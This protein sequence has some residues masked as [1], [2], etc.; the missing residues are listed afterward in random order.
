[1]QGAATTPSQTNN[2]IVMDNLSKLKDS[3]MTM[4]MLKSASSPTYHNGNSNGIN[5]TNNNSNSGMFEMVYVFF[6][7]QLFDVLFKIM[8]A[9]VQKAMKYSEKYFS[10]HALESLVQNAVGSSDEQKKK[11]K[12]ASI[13]IQISISDQ[14]N[15]YGQALLDFITNNNNTNHVSFKK[16]N[17]ILNQKDIIEIE[18][19]YFIL[20]KESI[21]TDDSKV[22][23]EQIIELFSYTKNMQELRT[24][25]NK[26]A[27]DYTIKIKNKLGNK[28]FYFNQHPMN[29]PT[30]IHGVKEFSKLPNNCHFTMK[31]FQTNRKF[32][33]LFG[34]EI[35][36]VKKRV[37][38]FSKNKKWYDKK[39][40]PYTL[41][42]LLSGSPGAGKTSTIKCLANETRRHIIN[43]N[44]NNDISKIQLEN[45][46]FNEMIVVLNVATGINEKYFIPLDQRIYVL[47]DI[48][49]Q[50]DLV[51]N[52]EL[53]FAL[54]KETKEKWC[55]QPADYEPTS[56]KNKNTLQINSESKQ[57]T[58]VGS[59]KIDLAFL[60]NLLDGVLEI[61]GRIVIMTSNFPEHLD[62]ALI[63]PG[64]IDVIANFQ[65]CTRQTIVQMIEFFYDVSLNVWQ[66]NS[67]FEN[68]E[69]F[70]LS[71][72]ELSK[73]MFE[74]INSH[75]HMLAT[76]LRN[77]SK[78]KS[79]IALNDSD[80]PKEDS[81]APKEDSDAPKEDSDAPKEDSEAPK[82]DSEAPKED[83]EAPKEHSEAPKEDSEAPK[84]YSEA[85]KEDSEAP[86]EET[87]HQSN[88][89]LEEGKVY[90]FSFKL[91]SDSDSAYNDD[92]LFHSLIEE[93]F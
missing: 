6:V 60:L 20:L 47:E 37:E 11:E 15:V 46:F 58:T 75:E 41:G 88:K 13:T 29:A 87:K 30:N 1:M 10:S 70:V 83:S 65:K 43:I 67:I 39:G 72:A 74:H 68:V 49:C 21:V 80:A 51:T 12:I 24:F 25:L 84:E 62:N 34:P 7:A 17:F 32:S 45:M 26:I 31:P 73:I 91:Y 89:E 33:N 4:M 86:K 82:E 2:P 27:H 42:L 8:P 40:I 64:R 66:H 56:L 14:E 55:P 79:A 76:L 81:D 61:P 90:N 59:E 52:R 85:P 48:D 53:K 5:N 63:R 93:T 44:L 28:I 3:L 9:L 92:S 35:S 18:E 19:E 69:D 36:V 23:T 16:Q 78:P 77:Y 57:N 54:E 50:S 38:F 22:E 71:P